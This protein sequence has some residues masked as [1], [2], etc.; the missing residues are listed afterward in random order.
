MI[1]RAEY[2]HSN[3][4]NTDYLNLSIIRC[5]LLLHSLIILRNM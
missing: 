4:D 1:N 5:V 3:I 2:T